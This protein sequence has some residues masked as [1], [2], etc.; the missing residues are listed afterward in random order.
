MDDETDSQKEAYMALAKAF[1]WLIEID[2]LNMPASQDSVSYTHRLLQ[3]IA[4][5]IDTLQQCC[6]F[7]SRLYIA[8]DVWLDVRAL[9]RVWEEDMVESEHS[10]SP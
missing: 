9:A 4:A 1:L 7:Q 5:R 10:A 8:D 6:D 2:Q 3:K